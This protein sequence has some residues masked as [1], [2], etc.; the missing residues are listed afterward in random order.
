MMKRILLA[1]CAMFLALGAAAQKIGTY[2]LWPD[3]ALDTSGISFGPPPADPAHT[4]VNLSNPATSNGTIRLIAFRA[5]PATACTDGA[6][7]K[8][9]HR[10]GNTINLFA[11]RGPFTVAGNM[12]KFTLSPPVD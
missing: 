2:A 8:F 9:F 10:S 12:H 5:A 7:V 1:S 4:Y 3:V 11:E 6:K